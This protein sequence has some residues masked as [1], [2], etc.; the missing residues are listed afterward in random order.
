M[1]SPSDRPDWRARAAQLHAL[2]APGTPVGVLQLPTGR[3]VIGEPMF[4]DA[5]PLART[6]PAGAF[7]VELVFATGEPGEQLIATARIAF[8]AAPIASWEVATGASTATRTAANG[9]PGYPGPLGL[10]MD[11]HTLPAFCK[12][13]DECDRAEWWHEV[14][15]QSGSIWNHACFQ[16]DEETPYNCALMS[17]LLS[18]DAFVSYWGLDERGEPVELVTD[19]NVAPI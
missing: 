15:A 3:I 10:F 11:A 9:Q 8:S 4:P 5:T 6:A 12:Y 17:P 14:P 13:V 7:P 16:P 1:A 18:D 19:F 2:F